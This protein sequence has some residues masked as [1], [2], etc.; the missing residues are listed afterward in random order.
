MKQSI[1][2]TRTYLQMT[3]PQQ[4]TGGCLR[5]ERVRIEKV[6]NCPPHFYR[7]LYAEVGRNWHWTD[8]IGWTD[9]EICA[10]LYREGL[11]LHV[12][13]VAG[14][15]AGYV[16]LLKHPNGSTEIAYFGLMPEF[17]GRGL[18]RHL[19]NFAVEHAWQEGANRVWLHTCSLDAPQALPNYLKRG[20]VAFKEQTYTAEIEAGDSTIL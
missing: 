15:P 13:Y 10:H 6:E 8:R 20:F 3:R 2:V 5:D 17:I 11:S 16:E 9:E 7:Y 1:E 19:L 14:A 18:G 4:L 12:M